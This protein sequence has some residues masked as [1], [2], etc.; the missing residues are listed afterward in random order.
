MQ[1][2]IVFALP[3]RQVLRALDVPDGATVAD[4]IASSTLASE[5]PETNLEDLQ[6]GVWGRLVGRDHVVAEGDRVELYRPL[7]MDPKDARRLKVGI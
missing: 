4:V 5:F 1:V 6:A 3:D 2:E 7:E